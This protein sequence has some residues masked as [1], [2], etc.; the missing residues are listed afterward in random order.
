NPIRNRGHDLITARSIAEPVARRN[1]NAR[2][3]RVTFEQR[4]ADEHVVAIVADASSPFRM[5]DRVQECQHILAAGCVGRN[6]R[7]HFVQLND[8]ENFTN[9]QIAASPAATEPITRTARTMPFAA[10]HA[11]TRS[12]TSSDSR[13][14]SCRAACTSRCKAWMLCGSS[15]TIPPFSE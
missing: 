15:L 3:L 7:H 6:S 14:N 4:T 12:R 5:R 9:A 8:T 10:C 1:D 11:C 13:D 2:V